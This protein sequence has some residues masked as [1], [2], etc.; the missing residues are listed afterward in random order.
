MKE[1]IQTEEEFV[2][3]FFKDQ[4]IGRFLELGAQDGAP[5]HPTEPCWNLLVKGWHGYYCE[6]NPISCGQLI[7]NT[8]PYR[9][10]TIILNTAVRGTDTLSLFYMDLEHEYSSASSLHLDWMDKQ[11]FGSA[12]AP[13]V[14]NVHSIGFSKLIQCVGCD[15]DFIS[16]DIE[17]SDNE[18][19]DSIDWNVFTNLKLVC[20]EHPNNNSFDRLAQ[21]GF[22]PLGITKASNV[23]FIKDFG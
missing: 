13:Y 18:A 14:I 19:I 4:P 6:P 1:L 20:T 11:S 7:R 22:V 23:F 12:Q 3:E 5:E 21:A 16:V 9:H 2:R 17:G 10:R 8:W 15:F